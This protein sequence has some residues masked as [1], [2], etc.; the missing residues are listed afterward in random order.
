MLIELSGFQTRKRS[1]GS[2]PR[3][4][5]MFPKNDGDLCGVYCTTFEPIVASIRTR[6]DF[7]RAERA[8]A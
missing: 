6:A 8:V 4:F 7:A 5:I 1:S 2:N 3:R